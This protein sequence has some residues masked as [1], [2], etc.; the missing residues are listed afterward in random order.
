M[1]SRARCLLATA[2]A[3][4]LESRLFSTIQIMENW[5]S[6][7]MLDQYYRNQEYVYHGS[8]SHNKTL[9][10]LDEYYEGWGYYDYYK[11]IADHQE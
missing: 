2:L 11:Y 9:D 7:W 5:V 3:R 4:A 10:W 8:F 1:Y 6:Q